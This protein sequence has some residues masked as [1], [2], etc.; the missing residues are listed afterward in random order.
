MRV[1]LDLTP[2]ASGST[3]VARYA[4]SLHD[5]LRDLG[6]DVAAFAVGRGRCA[7][8]T[9]TRRVGVPLR[10]VQRGWQLT[11]RPRVE[12]LVGAVDLAHCLDLVP[13]PSRAPQVMTAHDLLSLT[14]PELHSV[15]QV[16]QQQAQLVALRRAD[17]VLA[18]SA[19]TAQALAD[20]G[21][22]ADRVVVTPL[23]ATP[24]R[25]AVTPRAGRYVLAVGELA[26]RKNLLLLIDA[27]RAAR[28]PADVE[29][30]LVGPDGHQA[31]QVL[32]HTGDRVRALGRVD[33][34]Q[35]AA[36]YAG[37]TVFCFPS[38]AEGF[39][40]PVLEA[41]V[42]GTPVLASD[43][44]I[45]R[46]VAGDAAR[47]L[48]PQDVAAWTAALEELFADEATRSAM[49]RRGRAVAAGRTWEATARATH[50]AYRRLLG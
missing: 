49:S 44:E 3:G 17:L 35:L 41:L 21:V 25:D 9:G 11:G 28:L 5:A 34:A 38:L 4:L 18:N 27:F 10:V 20:H 26:V 42:A 32:E 23:G 19:V 33:D 22:A 39:G 45:I 1:A 13:A 24:P 12:Q 48:P 16:R 2:A 8:P 6:V 15:A 46:E 14:R 30:L 37:A 43:L 7:V 50:D 40:L 31:Q 29:L 36:L 47:L